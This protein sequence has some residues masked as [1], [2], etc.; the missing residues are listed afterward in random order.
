M[1][2]EHFP[3]YFKRFKIT[4]FSSKDFLKVVHPNLLK[5]FLTKQVCRNKEISR[6]LVPAELGVVL[7][8]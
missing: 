3:D 8:T 7:N 1:I 6:V 5:K 2:I 4:M